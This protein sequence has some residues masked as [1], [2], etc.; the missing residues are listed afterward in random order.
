M[1][2]TALGRRGDVKTICHPER[3]HCTPGWSSND[4]VEGPVVCSALPSLNPV[5][6]YRCNRGH[7]DDTD[8]EHREG[9]RKKLK[10]DWLRILRP[11][12]NNH[13]VVGCTC[14]ENDRKAT[15]LYPCSPAIKT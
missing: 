1:S 13:S 4:V 2:L 14:G 9:G 11:A 8:P 3:S 12:Q 10:L 6:S 15:D 5:F 7:S